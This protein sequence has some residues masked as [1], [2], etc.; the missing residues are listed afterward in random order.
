MP[1][2]KFII[3]I[4]NL[5]RLILHVLFFYMYYNVCKEDVRVGMELRHWKCSPLK[6]FIYLLVFDKTFRNLFYFRIGNAKYFMWYWLWPHPCFT[7]ATDMIVAPGFQ[8]VHPFST[9]VNAERIGKNFSVKHCVTVGNKIGGTLNRPKI[10]DNVTIHCNTVVVGNISIGDN[11]VIGSGTVLT[12]SVP[13]NC[14]V[15]GNP[16]YILRRNGIMVK[17]KL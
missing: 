4:V 6:G 1:L 2:S 13:D 11:V 14:E 5:P 3:S 9:I 17:E 15:V 8:C 12:K 7:M 16:A 10:G